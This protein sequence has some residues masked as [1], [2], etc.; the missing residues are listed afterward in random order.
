MKVKKQEPVLECTFFEFWEKHLLKGVGGSGLAFQDLE[1]ALRGESKMKPV[2]RMPSADRR[3][4]VFFDNRE[5]FCR[6]AS[7][8]TPTQSEVLTALRQA[9]TENCV[10]QM[11]MM[12]PWSKNGQK[13]LRVRG[14]GRDNEVLDFEMNL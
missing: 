7:M 13:K 4:D 8:P 5:M 14:H 1:P 6:F 11:E 12:I 2:F 3:S 10:N 9:L